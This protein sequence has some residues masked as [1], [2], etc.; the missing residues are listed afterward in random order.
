MVIYNAI[1]YTHVTASH[2]RVSDDDQIPLYILNVHMTFTSQLPL[3]S[4]LW[5]KKNHHSF[6]PLSFKIIIAWRER[7]PSKHAWW[8]KY[9]LP[10]NLKVF[11]LITIGEWRVGHLKQII[12]K[13]KVM[14]LT[15]LILENLQHTQ[16]P[17]NYHIWRDI[18]TE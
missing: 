5:F 7:K 1:K 11:L 2:N 14:F 15:Y 18:R 12:C 16:M 8:P 3:H 13:H 17:H 6:S 4:S 10:V 9:I